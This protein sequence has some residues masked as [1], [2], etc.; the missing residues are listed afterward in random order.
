MQN[1]NIRAVVSRKAHRK[2]ATK[3]IPSSRINQNKLSKSS[4]LTSYLDHVRKHSQSQKD[5]FGLSN[6]INDMIEREGSRPNSNL[7]SPKGSVLN[8]HR[9][10][11]KIGSNQE[12]YS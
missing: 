2:K 7:Y 8:P 9:A 1:S 10:V 6:T 5:K 3:P 4:N 12:S 11:K